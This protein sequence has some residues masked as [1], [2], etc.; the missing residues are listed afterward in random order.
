MDIEIDTDRCGERVR[1]RESTGEENRNEG[2]WEGKKETRREKVEKTLVSFED[3][4]RLQNG[5][6]AL[7][8]SRHNTSSGP[9]QTV[10]ASSLIARL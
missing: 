2:K 9:S 5:R 7:N 10:V 3:S 6:L 1:E 4:K 8:I